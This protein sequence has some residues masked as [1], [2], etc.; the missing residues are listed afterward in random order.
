LPATPYTYPPEKLLTGAS[1][2]NWELFLK[3]TSVTDVS[4]LWSA[5][6]NQIYCGRWLTSIAVDRE[7]AVPVATTH[8][9]AYQETTF[10]CSGLTI[11]KRAFLPV[12][13]DLH[14][15]FHLVLSFDNPTDAPVRATV[16]CD[17]HFPAFVWPGMYKVPDTTQ[18]NKRVTHREVDSVIVSSTV[19]QESEVR[20]FGADGDIA[21]T[22]LTDRGLSRAFHVDVAAASSRDVNVMMAFS[23]R[24]AD[25]ALA[26][27]RNAPSAAQ[28]LAQTEAAY[29]RVY[30]N[31]FVRTPEAAINRAF[32]WAKINTVRVQHRFPSGF[33]FTNDPSQDIVVTR[34]VAWFVT[35]SDYFTPEFSR[36]MLDLIAAFG[37][38]P[39]GKI[40]EFI[41]AC[42]DPPTRSDYDL[43]INDDTPL[44]VG[45]VHH[46]FAVT[47]DRGALER[48][49]PMTR[50]A[51][52]W[53]LSQIVDGMVFSTSREANVWGI[54]GWRNIIPQGQISGWVTEI[55]AEC[56]YAL[57][58][59]GQLA[60]LMG[61]DADSARYAAASDE[62]KAAVNANLISDRTGL[63]LLNID[64]DGEKH[65]DLT[66]DQIFPVLFGVADE[67]HKRKILDLL[68]TPEFWTQFGVR[69]V[70]K[71]QD[72][73]DPDYGIQLLGGV[74]PNLTA[75]VGYSGKSYS[76]RRL[77]SALRNI[78]RISEVEN[79]RAYYNVVPGLFPERLSGDS[80]KSRGMAMS[81]WMPPTYLWLVYE[82][83]LGFEPTVEGLRINP[84]V[85]SEWS[86]VGARDVPVMGAK[87]SMFYHRRRLHVTMN[88]ASRSKCEIYDEDVTRFVECDAPFYVAMRKGDRVAVF[89]ATD[90][91]GSFELTVHPPLSD[92]DERH[93]VS[94][95]EGGNRLL[96]LRMPVS[97]APVEERAAR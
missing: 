20:V 19:G 76:P 68:Y 41:N 67:Q 31:G 51:L 55:N 62:L 44:I 22:T 47:R 97:D 13:D 92:S 21:A 16:A 49:W 81:P 6:D 29:E 46:H 64:P 79:P 45:A 60:R 48:M 63:Y 52:E 96:N 17:V 88:V 59:G 11:R 54:S 23:H 30:R 56:V 4:G 9:A 33:G 72:E 90:V 83:V 26:T 69:T 32:D 28:A 82:G 5:V 80:F 70:G 71:H 74:W 39:G 24:G 89:V 73:Y 91:A 36:G 78:W 38:E 2:G 35:G 84:H 95:P 42:A 25:D 12:R 40:T 61:E 18:R 87:L 37:V 27:F 57:R 58:L 77:V 50:N 3:L 75:W 53:I 65:Y 7:R 86:W 8:S 1:F 15:V 66:G 93:R 34:D 10:R 94:L 85:P 43:N 14:Q